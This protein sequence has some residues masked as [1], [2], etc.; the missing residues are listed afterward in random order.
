MLTAQAGILLSASPTTAG[1]QTLMLNIA[2]GGTS[3]N[4]FIQANATAGSVTPTYTA[5]ASGFNSRTSQQIAIVPSF[6]FISGPNG[7]QPGNGNPITVTHGTSQALTV[8]F[9]LGANPN[10]SQALAGGQ[11]MMLTINSS[12]GG[13]GTVTPNPVT[14]NGGDNGDTIMFNAGAAGQSTV[15]SISG[16]VGPTFTINVN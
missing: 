9:V 1:S 11:T 14:I 7:F 4:F 5:T 8:F 6:P 16:G 10:G 2:G 15:L 12:N 3:A 13:A